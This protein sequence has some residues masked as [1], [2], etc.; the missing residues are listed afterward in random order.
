M[1]IGEKISKLRK[2]HELS[3]EQFAEVLGVSRQSVSKWELNLSYPDTERLIRISKLFDCSLDN[4]LKDEIEN[5]TGNAS[6]EQM[7]EEM[8]RAKGSLLT[9]LSYPPLFGWLV[10]VFSIKYQIENM[11]DNQQIILSSIGIF[12]SLV[13][14]IL[15]IVGAL[16]NL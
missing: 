8:K 5:A 11:K 14:T 3:Q 2:E 6:E 7:T 1:R 4:L 15:M 16:F 12:V 9:F 10:G 13:L